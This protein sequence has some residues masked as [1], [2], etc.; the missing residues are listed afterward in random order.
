MIDRSDWAIKIVNAE[1]TE[2]LGIIAEIQADA[3]RECASLVSQIPHKTLVARAALIEEAVILLKV[4][5]R[6]LLGP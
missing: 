3:M 2:Y 4:E 1:V 5:S 6:K